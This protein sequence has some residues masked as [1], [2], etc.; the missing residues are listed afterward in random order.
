MYILIIIESNIFP[1]NANPLSGGAALK[2]KKLISAL[3]CNLEV[4]VKEIINSV[5]GP[6]VIIAN[7][8][9]HDAIPTGIN[10]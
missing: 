4:P 6:S 10:I 1:I 8:N 5:A 3:N 2:K 9:L 7:L